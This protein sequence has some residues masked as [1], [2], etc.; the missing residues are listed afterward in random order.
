[1]TSHF[2]C[3]S[4]VPSGTTVQKPVLAGRLHASQASVHS[5]LQ[6]TPCAQNPESHSSLELHCA[7]PCFFPHEPFTHVLGATQSES[8]AQPVEQAFPLQTYGL[9]LRDDGATHW[10]D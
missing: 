2:S 5:A 3:G 1:V 9:Q 7:P 6:Q 4:R 8:W 10:P